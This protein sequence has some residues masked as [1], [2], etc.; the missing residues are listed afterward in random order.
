MTHGSLFSG[1]GGFDISA[2][3][4]GWSNIFHCEIDEWC[5]NKLKKHFP[6][7]K[8][9]HDITK[10]DFSIHRGT[11]DVLTGGFPCQ[12]LSV[13][14]SNG[15]VGLQGQKSGL[16]F[17]MLRA[18]IEIQPKWVICENVYGLVNQ[19][20]GTAFEEVCT[21]LEHQGYE[22]LPLVIP[23]IAAG[24]NHLRKRVW[25]VAYASRFGNR[26]EKREIQTRRDEPK[27][28]A[29]W[30]TEPELCRVYDG[31]PAELDKRRLK[32]LGNAIVPQIAEQIFYSIKQ[33]ED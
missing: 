20:S 18:V 29:W 7:S 21:G 12:D 33:F 14:S 24:A 6:N 8:S 25:I 16:W 32:G 1:I 15:K 26:M 23:A 3:R 2:D 10:T 30:H 13:A 28:D 22:V 5:R 31:L 19:D 17:E 27:H 4:V 9:Y 11:I